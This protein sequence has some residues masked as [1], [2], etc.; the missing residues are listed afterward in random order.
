MYFKRTLLCEIKIYNILGNRI[1]VL[2]W[3]TENNKNLI[4]YALI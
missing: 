3:N 4:N 2:C 1:S